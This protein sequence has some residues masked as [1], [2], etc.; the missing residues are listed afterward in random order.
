ML[1]PAK[2]ILECNVDGTVEAWLAA[3]AGAGTG[4]DA[5]F[6]GCTGYPGCHE[7]ESLRNWLAS[8]VVLP[9]AFHIGATAWGASARRRS[10]TR[11]S[12]P[13]STRKTGRGGSAARQG[14]WCE[15]MCKPS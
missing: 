13:S 9:G 3:L 12:R 11:P 6:G 1:D 4:L 7:A 15:P 14:R 2:I 10:F 8:H 5:F